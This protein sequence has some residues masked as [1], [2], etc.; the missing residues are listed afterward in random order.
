MP[1]GQE[2]KRVLNTGS[3]P[4]SSNRLHPAFARET[5]KEVRLDVNPTVQPDIVGSVANMRDLVPDGSFDAVWS[6]H[7]LEHLHFFE[8]LPALRELKRVIKSDG[9]ILLTCPDLE[10]ACDLLLKRG[11]HAD[12]Y[13]SPLG[14]IKVVDMIFGHAASIAAGNNYMCHNSGF[15]AKSLANAALEVGFYQ[16]RMARGRMYDLWALM[17]LPQTNVSTIKALLA[18]TPEKNL[19]S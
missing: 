9:F 18:H 19:F 3:G 10:A 14:P 5:W 8:V 7:Q 6:S 13:A 2:L 12:I 15:T 11:P 4:I 17:T 16:V 1:P